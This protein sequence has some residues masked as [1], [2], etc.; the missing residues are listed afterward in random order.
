MAPWS[1]RD[2]VAFLF[3]ETY[4]EIEAGVLKGRIVEG[5]V[6]VGRDQQTTMAVEEYVGRVVRA[7]RNSSHGLL[8]QLAGPDADVAATHTGALPESLPELAA[9]L[10]WS[11][12]ADPERLWSMQVWT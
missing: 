1:A 7:A 4:R 6:R 9:L 2:P 5:G 11:L 8:D 10:A 3:D 12:L